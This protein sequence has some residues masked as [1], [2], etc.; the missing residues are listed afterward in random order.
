VSQR[1]QHSVV[2]GEALLGHTYHGNRRHYF[3]ILLGQSVGEVQE[4]TPDMM[5]IVTYHVANMIQSRNTAA[6]EY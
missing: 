6:L 2:F 5:Y 4:N 1:L 3:R